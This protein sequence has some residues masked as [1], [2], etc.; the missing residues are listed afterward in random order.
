MGK[1]FY[2]VLSIFYY[3]LL[4][5]QVKQCWKWKSFSLAEQK[6]VVDLILRILLGLFGFHFKWCIGPFFFFFLLIPTCSTSLLALLALLLISDITVTLI[7]ECHCF[8]KKKFVVILDLKKKIK[9]I[10]HREFYFIINLL[11]QFGLH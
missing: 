10:K 7:M 3:Y 5:G 9:K 6:R 8:Q 11:H 4:L 1:A 2:F